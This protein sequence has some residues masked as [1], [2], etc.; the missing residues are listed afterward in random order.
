MIRRGVPIFDIARNMGTS[1]QIIEKY[2]GEQA[3]PLALATKLGS[4][5]G[6][7]DK[8]RQKRMDIESS[9]PTSLA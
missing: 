9:Y 1:V 4:V 7:G 2:Y 6:L 5:F 8:S 3:N